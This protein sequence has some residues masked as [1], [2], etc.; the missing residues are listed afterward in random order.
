MRYIAAAIVVATIAV[1]G[2]AAAQHRNAG[3]CPRYRHHHGG[4]VSDVKSCIRRSVHRW[5]VPGG[6]HKAMSVARCESSFHPGED[7]GQYSGVYQIGD[8][9]WRT[10]NRPQRYRRWFGMPGSVH[11]GAA[12]VVT[13]I[14][15]AHAGGWS[16]WS[17]S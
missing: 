8:S 4:V 7:Y 17:C 13:A 3:P 2:N 16:A 9:E 15:H 5:H 11:N 6:T 12:N 10:W 1:P 14:F